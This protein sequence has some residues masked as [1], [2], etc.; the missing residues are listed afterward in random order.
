[1]ATVSEQTVG[2]LPGVAARRDETGGR[3]GGVGRYLRRNP[4][5]VI[6]IVL[7]LSLILF[8]LVGAL[9]YD[10]NRARAL[11]VLPEMPP[12]LTYPFG[13]DSQGRDLFAVMILGTPMT[14]RIGLL[15][16]IIGVA[17]GTVLAFVAA[18]YGGVIDALIRSA[19]DVLL[20]VPG[21]MIL[22]I[23]A[24]TVKSGLTVDQMALVVAS[25]AWLWPTRTIR[26]Q[27]LSLRERSYIQIAKLSG[28][29]G[30]EIIMKELLPNLLPYIGASLVGATAAAVLASIG[31]E[32]IGLGPMEAPTLGMTF[33][34][35]IY[36]SAL[37]HGLWWWFT[38]PLVIIVILFLGL[39]CLSSGLDEVANPR[40]RRE[41]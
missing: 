10:T 40:L 1:V 41:V 2:T 11:S 35:V 39:F 8:S 38:P 18:Y 31:L 4:S 24:V 27:A 36:H 14:L 34:W 17:I 6:G 5:L 3:A 22:I 19:V 15:A 13:S 37:L 30:P 25:L 26:A 16:G 33:Y 23:L 20:T 21:L 29:S 12:S 9:T 32:A 28:V 7:L